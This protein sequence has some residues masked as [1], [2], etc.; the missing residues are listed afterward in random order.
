[1]FWQTKLH[2]INKLSTNFNPNPIQIVW[3]SIYQFTVKFLNDRK[4]YARNISSFKK[5]KIIINSFI[6]KDQNN[7]EKML[8]SCKND[9]EYSNLA[10]I[11]NLN[12]DTQ[13]N[14][15]NT[16]QNDNTVLKGNTLL[17]C[18][19]SYHLK[20]WKNRICICI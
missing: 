13:N 11:T 1:M 17:L 4:L 12:D 6:T 5:K 14:I 18:G 3:M 9:T 8:I 20:Y 7:V 16:N 15:K 10:T 2:K 19:P